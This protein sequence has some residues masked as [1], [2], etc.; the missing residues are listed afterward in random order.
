MHNAAK[1]NRLM[2]IVSALFDVDLYQKLGLMY[3]ASAALVREGISHAMDLSF[4]AGDLANQ[5][6]WESLIPL[7]GFFTPGKEVTADSI[8]GTTVTVDAVGGETVV[9]AGGEAVGE[10]FGGKEG[11]KNVAALMKLLEAAPK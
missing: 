2:G 1:S 5:A 11:S 3:P 8:L 6:A 10:I 4:R 7:L 9:E